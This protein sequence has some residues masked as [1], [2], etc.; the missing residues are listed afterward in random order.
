MKKLLLLLTFA[1]PILTM[2]KKDDGD[3]QPEPPV[4]WGETAVFKNG[5]EA[6]AKSYATQVDPD[7]TLSVNIDLFNASQRNIGK[8][9]FQNIPQ[10]T[11]NVPLKKKVYP[12]DGSAY[13][14]YF[15]SNGDILN[16]FYD[17]LESE[18]SNSLIITSFDEN[19]DEITG[20]FTVT[21][22]VDS[23]YNAVMPALEDTLRFT[24]GY[25]HTKIF[26]Y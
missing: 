22:V 24:G 26:H 15:D 23:S 9:L 13:A 20:S 19:S 11:G 2:C 8:L 16:G 7:S 5:V 6:I 3:P 21:L 12:T 14:V 25:F 10:R 1:M 17:V 4:Y 18:P